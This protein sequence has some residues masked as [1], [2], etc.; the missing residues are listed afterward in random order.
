MTKSPW[1]WIGGVT[2]LIVV[3]FLGRTSTGGTLKPDA[4]TQ[5]NS[6]SNAGLQIK[7]GATSA[8]ANV[9][10]NAPQTSGAPTDTSSN[11]PEQSCKKEAQLI[12]ASHANVLIQAHYSAQY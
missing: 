10:E 3:F 7:A 11:D 1:I 2:L 12:V 6:S 8:N 5:D 9:A 4:S